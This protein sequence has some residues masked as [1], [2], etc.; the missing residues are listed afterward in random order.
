MSL[1]KSKY[2]AYVECSKKC[3]LDEHRKEKSVIDEQTQQRLNDGA[4]LGKFA[5]SF[6]GA[7][8]DATTLK[9]DGS[10]DYDAMI[11]KT[12]QLIAAGADNICEASFSYNQ[13]YCAVDILHKENG[14]YAIYEVKSSKK[15]KDI[16]YHDVAFQKYVLTNCGVKVTGAYVM[17]VNGDYERHGD[18]DAKQLFVA[19]SV[20]DE[21]EALQSD[22]ASK[23]PLAKLLLGS[24]NEPLRELD[25]GCEHCG[26]WDYCA[27]DIPQPTVLDLCV[28]RGQRNPK[29]SW[30]NSGVRTLY[31]VKDKGYALHEK[32]QLQVDYGT[33]DKG[34]FVDKKRISKFLKT[35][36]QPLYFLDFET[37]SPALPPFD[38]LKPGSRIPFQYS[39]HWIDSSGRLHQSAFLGEPEIDPRRALAEQL[40]KDIPLDACTLAW[41]ASVEKNVVKDLAEQFDDLRMHLLNICAHILD[42]EDPFSKLMMYKKE[43]KG[44]SSIKYVLPA[45]FPNDPTLNYH[46]LEGVHNGSE[47]MAIYPKMKDMSPTERAK[48]R[49]NLLDY[50]NLDTLAMV[51]I[52]EEL[53]KVSK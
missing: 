46:N 4:E 12:Q 10:L 23:M 1:S 28:G 52:W 9:A 19:E 15:V 20:W 13:T 8:I 3:W 43:M 51:R 35:L 49:R 29:W 38:G 40:C 14:G 16:H 17:H 36:S 21:I 11:R 48:A 22:V 39:L 27:R 31:D 42:L 5:R 6:F 34:T 18:I 30:Y 25:K 37:M 47:A 32:L 53:V 44:R 50:C 24:P 41:S 2:C 26:Y 33:A 45:L 7:F